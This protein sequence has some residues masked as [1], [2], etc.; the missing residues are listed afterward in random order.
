[1]PRYVS[2]IN[3]TQQGIQNYRDTVRRVEDAR[4]AGEQLGVRIVDVYWTWADL[5]SSWFSR[6]PMGRVG[7]GG[8]ARPRAE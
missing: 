4:A 2:L 5:T 6:R 1:M 3:W 7:N 8:V